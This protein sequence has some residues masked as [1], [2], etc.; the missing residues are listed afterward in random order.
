M[1]SKKEL[2]KLAKARLKDSEILFRNRRY[3]SAT[4][5]CGYAVELA[6]K[7]RICRT[8][9]WTG[10]P[11]SNRE[12]QDY[13]SLKTHNLDV[14]LVFSGVEDKIKSN[15][16]SEWSVVTQWKPEYRYRPLGTEN[17]N[18]TRNMIDATEKLIVALR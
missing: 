18:T 8:L 4:Y 14:L 11:S 1:I 7:A 3:D 9:K 12:F 5:L 17:K 13:K 2:K 10:F 15:F 6:L 16:L